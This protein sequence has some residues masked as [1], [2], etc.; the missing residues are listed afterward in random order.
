MEHG[1]WN[2]FTNQYSV[3]KTLRFELKPEGK[4][5]KL[6]SGTENKEN[7]QNPLRQLIIKD[8]ARAEAYK[9]LKK[10]IDNVHRK[11]L[12]IALDK[13]NIGE[14][15]QQEF[16]KLFSV[17]FENWKH[18][19]NDKSKKFKE[20]QKKLA[21]K[22][23][24]LLDSN[25]P[26]FIDSLNEQLA[27]IQQN[28]TKN[29]EEIQVLSQQIKNC[30]QQEE[31]DAL[32]K[33][34][35]QL[36][37]ENKQ[38]EK[39]LEVKTYSNA[40]SLHSKTETIFYITKVF[41]YQDTE[42][43]ALIAK[44]NRFHSYFTGFNKNRANVYNIT[45]NG[46]KD[47][48]WNFL[49]TSI[50]HRLFEQ[51]IQFHFENI[52]K[53]ENIK[54]NIE[55]GTITNIKN[56]EKK[57][58]ATI[59]KEQGWDWNEKINTLEKQTHV[60]IPLDDFFS[61]KYFLKY[62]GQSGIDQYNGVVDGLAAQSEQEK[63][64]GINE[65]TNL[66]CQQLKKAG[67][68]TGKTNF[69]FMKKFYK[70]ILSL[71]ENDFIEIINSDDELLQKIQQFVEGISK[72]QKWEENQN[73]KKDILEH[74]QELFVSLCSELNVKTEVNESN[75][76]IK[77][78]Y[79]L[80][81]KGIEKMSAE[82]TGN[83]DA[84]HHHWG[85]YVDELNKEKKNKEIVK[86]KTQKCLS[87]LDI[88]RI[89]ERLDVDYLANEW[90]ETKQ[91]QSVK[92]DFS[93]QIYIENKFHKLLEG[94]SYPYKKE[95]IK[96]K[97]FHATKDEAQKLIKK[98]GLTKSNKDDIKTLK[99]FLDSCL[100]I[101][102]FIKFFLVI[103]KDMNKYQSLDESSQ[104]LITIVKLLREHF[105]IV[106]LYDQARNYLTKK[107]YSMDKFKLNFEN[108]TLAIGWDKNKEIANTA[109][110]F[111]KNR[112]FYLG[113][114]DKTHNTLFEYIDEEKRDAEIRKI[115]KE[116]TTKESSIKKIDDNSI[117]FKE[118]N[119]EII[120][121]KNKRED[122]LLLDGNTEKY[123]KKIVYKQIAGVGKN[124][125]NLMV[126]DG[127]T[128]RITGR[129]D[130]DQV[131]R[132]L[133]EAK[134]KYLPKD[135][136][137]IRK[138][139]TYYI[140]SK[141]FNKLD[142]SKFID[143]YKQRI[144]EY[145]GFSY[146]FHD[147]YNNFNDF[148][149][150]ANSQSYD[151]SFT[152]IPE[153]YIE[154]KT[155][156][157]EL[158]L[159]QI[160]SKDF[161][162]QSTGKDNLH[163]SYW[164][165]L[166][167]EDNLKNIVL[168]LNGQAEIFYRKASIDYS[169][170]KQEKGHHHEELNG[171][172]DRP[173]IKDR[174]FSED[175]YFFHCPITLNFSPAGNEYLNSNIN[176]HIKR[177]EG[178][179]NIIGIDRGEKHLLYYS[180]INQKGGV[181]EQG[182]FNTIKNSYKKN[183]QII[184]REIDYQSKLDTKEKER[185]GARE[186]WEAIE[187]IKELK[188]GYLS[189]VVH[190]LADLIIKH[191]AIVVLEDLNFGFKRG[192]FKVEKQVYQKFERALIEK[193]N[194]LSFKD[195]EVGQCGHHL[196][197]YQLTNKFES[198]EKLGKQSGILFYTQASYTSK[199]DPVTGYIQNLYPKYTTEEKAKEFFCNFDSIVWNGEHFEFTYDLKK[200]RGMTGIHDDEK[201]EDENKK[202]NNTLIKT[203][204]TVHSHIP[205]SIY[206]NQILTKDNKLLEYKNVKNEKWKSHKIIN[207][208]GCLVD[209][210]EKN[211]FILKKNKDYRDEIRNKSFDKKLKFFPN[212]KKNKDYRDEI[213]NKSFDKKLKFFPK[214]IAH[215]N[216]LLSMRVTDENKRTILKDGGKQDNRESDFIVSPVAPFFDSRK[217]NDD[218][219]PIDSDANGAYNIARKGIIILNKIVETQED[220]KKESELSLFISK[221][222][223]QNYSQDEQAVS[224][225]KKVYEKHTK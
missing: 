119:T 99:E 161:S 24:E 197:G 137:R 95:T 220:E 11:F 40:S 118:L 17:A 152:N 146:K 34:E 101:A 191:S 107:G 51:N 184:E 170:E 21:K 103:E 129:K 105:N 139:G 156:R 10:D 28:K 145:T 102:Q 16:E 158:Y 221:V 163:T 8:E 211:G 88:E 97:G 149:D 36:K 178:N 193:L 198:F 22:I 117:Q 177:Y 112:M 90:K 171:K 72:Q 120:Q 47:K 153:A 54:N 77:E 190:K 94:Y 125:Q 44:F 108:P 136:N 2:K 5:K 81:K 12:S 155:E 179:I 116:I 26:K 214:V 59:L 9:I 183:G 27:L 115:E 167:D 213:R 173:I 82:V 144:V 148:T 33:K 164:K 185:A 218:K 55:S 212:L 83:Y 50:A 154:R 35:K 104:F 110:L 126:I 85:D 172:F 123:Y 29:E 182:S 6:L 64:Q 43:Q 162:L 31:K 202:A 216:R 134:N 138:E 210:F 133:E 25:F 70:Q 92:K 128:R 7:G 66:T 1:I 131:N 62:F 75:I 98:G 23:N 13:E 73:E 174:R 205:R 186:N 86:T 208:N 194:Y 4:T 96:R 147:T 201:E 176:H 80:N 19:K 106:P 127:I 15:I 124:I 199:V 206:T 165:Y 160:Y 63:I 225:Q 224:H 209:L 78:Q 143:Y 168:K 181:L 42:K 58:I 204:W 215:F 189:Q 74:I 109:V 200:L 37:A 135:I 67:Y 157:E 151:I 195:R 222:E 113:I 140:K 39:C 52:Q 111:Q 76:Q 188:A 61:P 41:Y 84:F 219:L 141:K 65:I 20:I 49:A 93:V 207:V 87:F 53:W 217:V 71:K 180:V 3:N 192:R 169:K 159:F 30:S 122:L 196:K 91:D 166:F 142:L 121:L 46:K 57:S 100:E 56:T 150:Q 187:N 14:D 18:K 48:N 203:Q 32:R 130:E 223:W 79:F 69:P 60:D 38:L 175:K 68:T 89:Y 45:G 132:R 114:M